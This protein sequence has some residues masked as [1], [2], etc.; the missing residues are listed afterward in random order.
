MRMFEDVGVPCLLRAWSIS[1][2]KVEDIKKDMKAEL[3]HWSAWR[4]KGEKVFVSGTNQVHIIPDLLIHR[5]PIG[6]IGMG[7][8]F[9]H[10]G[11]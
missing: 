5:S 11:A 9:C 1:A 3:V 7:T 4:C 8:P 2:S 10:A 6:S